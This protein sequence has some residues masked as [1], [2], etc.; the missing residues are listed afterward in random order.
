M[1]A[2]L[3]ASSKDAKY[4]LCL[5]TPLVKKIF[6]GRYIS[7]PN[8]PSFDRVKLTLKTLLAL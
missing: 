2:C 8:F 3:N 6:F 1:F 7:S 4:S 5:P